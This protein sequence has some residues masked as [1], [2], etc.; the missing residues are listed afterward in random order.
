[1]HFQLNFK[2]LHSADQKYLQ[3]RKMSA[4][5]AGNEVKPTEVAADGQVKQRKKKAIPLTTEAFTA[6]VNAVEAMATQVHK[7]YSNFNKAGVRTAPQSP[8]SKE[9][10]AI[11][12]ML[13]KVARLYE[14]LCR[15]KKRVVVHNVKGFKQEK[16][17]KK[18]A[19][20]FFN[21]AGGFADENK[22]VPVAEANGDG[23]WSIAQAISTTASYVSRNNLKRNPATKSEITFDAKMKELFA[24][25][26]GTIKR[27]KWHTNDAGEIVTTQA[28]IQALLP[29]LFDAKVPVHPTLFTEAEKGRM[30]R[31]GELLHKQ[32]AANGEVRKAKEDA[33]KLAE[34]AEKGSKKAVPQA[35]PAV[36]AK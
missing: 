27:E 7:F 25:V 15:K 13:A 4:P 31:R 35:A 1:V 5:A 3:K 11:L 36:V 33:R 29:K 16:F 14:H 12:P 6:K 8:S 32:T 2:N 34:R 26:I 20:G 28:A 30:L 17:L 10:G 19:I 18:E 23:I 9:T 21:E 24:P 22:I